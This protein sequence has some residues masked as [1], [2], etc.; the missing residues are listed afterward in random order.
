MEIPASAAQ[1]AFLFHFCCCS[2]Q[3]RQQAIGFRPPSISGFL[4]GAIRLSFLQMQMQ[5]ERAVSKRT[6]LG[7]PRH[8]QPR[9]FFTNHNSIVR[10]LTNPM[11]GRKERSF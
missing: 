2:N 7:T 5:A 6:F 10:T 8:S 4:C 11:L 9:F 3:S 1:S